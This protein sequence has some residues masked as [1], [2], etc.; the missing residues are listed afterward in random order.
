MSPNSNPEVSLMSCVV[1][2]ESIRKDASRCRHCGAYQYRWR[3]WISTISSIL[4]IAVIVLSLAGVITAVVTDFWK[5]LLWED[6]IEV[7]AYTHQHLIVSNSGSGDVFIE[8]TTA[9]VHDLKYSVSS[10]VGETVSKDS[11]YVKQTDDN[12]TEVYGFPVSGVSNDHWEKMARRE[13]EG[14]EPYIFSKNH[15]NLN[16]LKENMG[17]GLRTFDAKCLLRFRSLRSGSEMMEQS[18]P[19][20]GIFVRRP[21]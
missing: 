7:I 5:E 21:S 17:E 3:N 1:C 14:V 15:P 4:G 8:S 11:F 9:E 18:F 2:L 10:M 20:E 16:V 19:C 12:S 6:R 13:I